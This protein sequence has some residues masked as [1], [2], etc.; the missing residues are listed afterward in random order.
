MKS[1]NTS[2]CFP[3]HWFPSHMS[4][5]YFRGWMLGVNICPVW[6]VGGPSS[7]RYA[8][9]RAANH[10]VWDVR[11]Y[12]GCWIISWPDQSVAI[13]WICTRPGSVC[14]FRG[15]LCLRKMKETNFLVTPGC[16]A[17]PVTCHKY[18]IYS[19]WQPIYS[20]AGLY[21][22]FFVKV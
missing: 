22:F 2:R 19:A 12:Y 1:T 6:N 8:V 4:H 15:H 13:P 21:R 17:A 3:S 20:D 7:G 18:Q 10:F 9:D 16:I 11:L 5:K 14:S